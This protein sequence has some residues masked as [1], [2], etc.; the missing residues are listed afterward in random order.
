MTMRI[1]IALDDTAESV[2]A[3]HQAVGLFNVMPDVH[4]LVINVTPLPI[5]WAGTPGFGTVMP[6]AALPPPPASDPKQSPAGERLAQQ[7]REAGIPAP[8]VVQVTGDAATEICTAAIRTT[9]TSSLSVRTTRTS[10][11]DCWTRPSQQ[12][13][14]TPA[15]DRSSSAAIV[16]P[17]ALE[18]IA[19]LNPAVS[20]GPTPD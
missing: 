4:Y 15:G 6:L 14:C 11:N 5:A 8:D 7:A 16:T 9:S 1:L 12:K 3:A 13:S 18:R 10:S 17:K 19:L 2:H 20:I